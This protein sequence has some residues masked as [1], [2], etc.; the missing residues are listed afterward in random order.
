VAGVVECGM[1]YAGSI[2]G[3]SAVDVKRA[4][5]AFG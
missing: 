1:R 5:G 4:V 3:R 2:R